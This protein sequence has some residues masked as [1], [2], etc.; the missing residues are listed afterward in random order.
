[1]GKTILLE[2]IAKDSF[3][4]I[5]LMPKHNPGKPIHTSMGFSLSFRTLSGLANGLYSVAPISRIQMFVMICVL[6]HWVEAFPWL[7]ATAKAVSKIL[8]QK[9]PTELRGDQEMTGK[10]IS[11]DK[12]YNLFVRSS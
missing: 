10:L 2:A 11:Q 5:P 9:S 8:L 3:L 7:R 12:L 1:M 4:G 6:F